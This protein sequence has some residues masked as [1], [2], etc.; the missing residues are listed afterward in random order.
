MQQCSADKP[1]Q[2]GVSLEPAITCGD[3]YC[4][5]TG[6]ARIAEN[7][8]TLCLAPR[9][10][11]PVYTHELTPSFSSRAKLSALECSGFENLLFRIRRIRIARRG[12]ESTPRAL[13]SII[14][15][16]PECSLTIAS[17][18]ALPRFSGPRRVDRGKINLYW[19]N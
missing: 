17:P 13:L 14:P 2:Y 9:T 10:R 11:Q 19:T 5:P 15:N 12:L 7:G 6:L 8:H 18:G 16:V 4:R 3:F 1:G